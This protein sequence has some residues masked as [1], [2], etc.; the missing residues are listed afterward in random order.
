MKTVTISLEDE[1]YETAS[2]QAARSRKS[3]GEFLRDLFLSGLRPGD[4]AAKDG[5]AILNSLWEMAD[6]RPVTP[7]SAGPLSRDD[8]YLRGLSRH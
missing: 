8:L 6:G 2:A 4:M 7:G 3:L 1:L 5:S